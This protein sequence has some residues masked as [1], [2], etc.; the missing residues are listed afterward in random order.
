VTPPAVLGSLIDLE[1]EPEAEQL[2]PP[3]DLISLLDDEILVSKLPEDDDCRYSAISY[4]FR[5]VSRR[6]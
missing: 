5:G 3:L 6:G 4:Q 1:T 2:K